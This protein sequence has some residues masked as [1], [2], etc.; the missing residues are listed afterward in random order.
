MGDALLGAALFG[1]KRL[2]DRCASIDP[3]A[4]S[5]SLVRFGIEPAVE[6]DVLAAD[7]H[8]R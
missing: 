7:A 2:R 8:Q 5:A 3:R 6:N 4:L 1:G